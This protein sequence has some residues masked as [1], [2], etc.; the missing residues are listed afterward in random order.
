LDGFDPPIDLEEISDGDTGSGAGVFGRIDG[1][2]FGGGGGGGAVEDNP[3]DGLD[4]QGVGGGDGAPSLASDG[5]INNPEVGD[6][7]T[8]PMI[9]DGGQVVFYRVD[10]SVEGGK[11]IAAQATGTYTLTINDVDLSVY[12]ETVCPDPT[13]PTGYGEPITTSP[14]GPIKEQPDYAYARWAGTIYGR[15]AGIF[16][17]TGTEQYD[18]G[19]ITMVKGSG[20]RFGW[21]TPW[22]SADS[23]VS[24]NFGIGGVAGWQFRR[25]NADGTFDNILKSVNGVWTA[26]TPPGTI[27]LYISGAFLFSD[28]DS[29][30]KEVAFI[31]EGRQSDDFDITFNPPP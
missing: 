26:L 2:G 28:D 31:W 27:I 3:V 5:D 25:F 23:F 11:V 22:M 30:D 18:T 24:P 29:F 8:A 12:A 9:C 4:A 6:T 19:W 1:G 17:G 7:L 13:S 21:V 15:Q 10:P 20:T 14:T 16:G